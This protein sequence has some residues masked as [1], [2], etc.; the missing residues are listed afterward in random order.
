[1]EKSL[2]DKVVEG[3]AHHAVRGVVVGGC[4]GDVAGG[5]EEH[6]P[7][8]VLDGAVGPFFQD[9]PVDDGKNGADEEEEQQA[10]VDLAVGKL[11]LGPNDS[12][13]DTGG[14]EHPSV[15]TGVV[16]FLGG[17]A[18]VLDGAV[19][20]SQHGDLHQR[21]PDG[22]DELSREQEPGRELHVVAQL[23]VRNKS[24]GLVVGDVAKRLEEHHGQWLTRKHVTDDKFRHHVQ[25]H[26]DV[27]DGVDHAH[28]N[29]EHNGNEQGNDQT[30][31]G[32][33]CVPSPHS[34]DGQ[35]KENQEHG[36]KPPGGHVSVVLLHEP[37]VH[38]GLVLHL[39]L[40]DDVLSV[41]QDGVDNC[42][43]HRSK[44]Q[45]VT[46]GKR[47]G[48]EQ[49]RVRLVC[50]LVET[51][52][53]RDNSQHVVRLLGIVK[54]P[55]TGDG[56]VLG[57]PSVGVVDGRHDDPEDGND[58]DG[59]GEKNRSWRDQWRPNVG[60]DL[61]PVQTEAVGEQ[62]QASQGSEN[63]VDNDVLGLDPGDPG[64]VRERLEDE[65]GE[66]VPAETGGEHHGEKCHSTDFPPV[67][68]NVLV[69]VHVGQERGRDQLLGVDHRRRVDQDLSHDSRKCKPNT[70]GTPNSHE[71]ESPAKILFVEHILSKQDVGSIGGTAGTERDVTH[72][73]DKR[74]LLE[75]ER[76]RVQ[77]HAENLDVGEKPS[78]RRADG[79]RQNR[80]NIGGKLGLGTVERKQ[81]VQPTADG[82]QNHADNPHPDGVLGHRWVVGRGNRS[83]DL[84]VWRVVLNHWRR[85]LVFKNGIFEF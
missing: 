65:A 8:E 77:L 83:S 39:D 15:G 30:P 9:Q 51:Q 56:Q 46:D 38:V 44:R 28:G 62:T 34:S 22:G 84:R 52:V 6:G 36:A 13:D 10:V 1:M 79:P 74:M 33:L 7:V 73:G 3:D 42:G 4:W 72:D 14:E 70:L 82:G 63:L 75:I 47:G 49:R 61:V 5:R 55:G 71:V 24:D 27:G 40:V 60:G 48:E 35:A 43:G 67:G 11:A 66:K 16:V 18:Q 69:D 50:L 54:R 19:G 12:P 68:G 23:H 31:D 58:G 26:G 37:G 85:I 78:P 29:Q 25:P 80:G 21:T 53:L 81:Q 59:N 64:K 20:P 2:L 45:T 41:E 17:R 57:V 32:H 76:A